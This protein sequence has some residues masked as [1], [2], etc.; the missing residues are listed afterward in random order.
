[1]SW[2]FQTQLNNLKIQVA[3]LS[4]GSVTNPLTSALNVASY[5]LNNLTSL[6]GTSGQNLSLNTSNGNNVIVNSPLRIPNHPL[7]I[8]NNTS[9]DSL[10][11]SDSAGDTSLFRIDGSG[12]V[13][14]KAN[15]SVPLT[16]DFTV[17]GNTDLTGNLLVGGTITATNI[18]AGNVVNNITAG[19]GIIKTGTSSNPTL[20]TNLTASTGI[21]LTPGTGTALGISNTGVTSIV[22]GTG[23]SVSGATGAVTVTASVSKFSR[24]GTVGNTT[25]PVSGGTTGYQSIAFQLGAFNNDI[26]AG[27][28]PDPNGVW[29]LDLNPVGLQ[30]TGFLNTGIVNIGLGNNVDA[31]VYYNTAPNNS[32]FGSPPTA[33]SPNRN[34]ACTPLIVK[35]SDLIA[36]CPNMATALPR[37]V[38]QNNS[39]DTL[40]VQTVPNAIVG[41]YFPNGVQ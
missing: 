7:I 19:T 3:Q 31:N 23:V 36:T 2:N 14:V 11:V 16:S 5:P 13:G 38:F 30:L 35:I 15:P 9:A 28:S 12:N 20:S 40:W 1:M 25:S 18:N 8:T 10:T 4:A 37:L 27:T 21:S 39:T 22:A 41:I 6:T 29:L 24:I 32:T 26:I 33:N 34:G 17:N